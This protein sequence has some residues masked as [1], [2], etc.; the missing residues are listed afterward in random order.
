MPWYKAGAV[1]AG[2]RLTVRPGRATRTV[3]LNLTPAGRD[4]IRAGRRRVALVAT[5][6]EPENTGIVTTLR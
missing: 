1:V 3:T 5:E 2:R 6:Y 4:F